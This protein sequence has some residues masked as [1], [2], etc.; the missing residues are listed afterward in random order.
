VQSPDYVGDAGG[1]VALVNS[2]FASI[3]TPSIQLGL[4]KAICSRSGISVDDHYVNVDFAASLGLNVYH[5][6]CFVP[7]PDI[8]EW[9]FGHA[10][11]GDDVPPD[12]YLKNFRAEIDG[13]ATAAGLTVD[14]L[15]ALRQ[16]T[17]PALVTKAAEKL[18]LYPVVGFTSTFQQNVSALALARAV[19]RER[20]DAQTVMGGSNFHGPMGREH[21]RAFAWID[22]VVTGEADH[23][24]ADL[25]ASLLRGKPAPDLPGILSR[26]RPASVLTDRDPIYLGP[27][28]DLPIPDFDAYFGALDRNGIDP[29]E[30]GHPI[31]MPFETSRG[32]WWGAKHHCTFCGLN[33]VGMTFRAK[34]PERAAAEVGALVSR[35][36]IARLDATDNI[37][38]RKKMD[39]LMG[40][41]ER[42]NLPLNLFYEIKSNVS[43]EDVKKMRAAGIRRVQPGI[44]SFSSHVLKLMS[45]G[46]SGLQN[47][48]A[49]RWF[50]AFDVDPLWNILYGFPGERRSD[51]DEQA[52]L[53]PWLTHLPPP[54]VVTRIN[55]DRF[56]PNI[57]VPELR[58]Q[59]QDI[60]PFASY[61]YLYPDHIDLEKA[62]YH[63]TGIPRDGLSED[64]YGDFF[65]TLRHWKRLWR[66]NEL[67]PFSPKPSDRPM[68][69]FSEPEP[70]VALL[71][72][73]RRQV[74]QPAQV[75]L[76]GTA[77]RVLEAFFLKPAAIRTVTDRL[78]GRGDNRA[79]LNRA[80]DELQDLHLIC[81][82]GD[83]AL[84]L[85]VCENY[86][87]DRGVDLQGSI[88][89]AEPARMP[90]AAMAR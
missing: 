89:V 51:Y 64:D 71:S 46:V 54:Q 6:C 20:A 45:K 63:F 84:A 5:S 21:F 75:T 17:I 11:F 81:L 67:S 72:D 60:R 55:L 86:A 35:Y 88:L 26:D 90:A 7:S 49:L 32:C 82:E 73:T 1:C 70:G 31:S 58:E 3:Q 13:F 65:K 23:F 43:A 69:T 30:L 15:V 61:A 27:M 12:P 37:V 50:S 40:E 83:V 47:I 48:N 14:Q 80:L 16:S 85:P 4:I 38:E 10:A 25:F 36:G 39:S 24:V 29:S 79:A 22:H 68:L 77:F 62:S 76:E 56:S 59:F 44:E 74:N 19:K 9:L 53:I 78:A 18:A 87:L 33:S 42:L 34:S 52:K 8:G 28:D 57:E 66:H 2:P 41:L